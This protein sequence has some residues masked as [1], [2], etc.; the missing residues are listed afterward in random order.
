MK[1]YFP[2]TSKLAFNAF[3]ACTIF[4]GTC[5]LDAA[6]EKKDKIDAAE[7]LLALNRQLD[8][9]YLFD[10]DGIFFIGYPNVYSPVIFPGAKL[11]KKIPVKQGDRFL[12]IG[13]GTGV[14]SVIAALDG[15]EVVYSIDINPDAV[16]NTLLNAETH[17]VSDKMKVMQGDMF[18]PLGNEDLFDIIY[19]NIPFCHKNCSV[20][21]LSMLSRS[22]YDPEHA[23]LYR[24]LKEGRRHLKSGGRMLLGYSTTHG[25]IEVMFN[26]AK[27]FGW[28]VTLLSKVGDETKDFITV[29]LYEFR[30]CCPHQE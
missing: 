26:W 12:E 21:E 9:I 18:S 3:C 16:A 1:K 24:Y 11:Q 10:Y 17:G 5:Q 13:C 6:V 30:P 29:E 20:D 2:L 15:A 8:D 14:F 23:L 25:D 7:E 19:F 27:E 28:D 4:L 22:I